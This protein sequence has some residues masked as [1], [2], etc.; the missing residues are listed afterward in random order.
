MEGPIVG[1]LPRTMLCCPVE[2][3]VADRTIDLD[4]AEGNLSLTGMFL[5]VE[6]LPVNAPVHIRFAVVPNVE[7]DGVI[8]CSHSG[9]AG[10]EFASTT[11]PARQGLYDLIAEF[12]PRELLAA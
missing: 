1:R 6:K 8:R 12:T 3:R 11:G 10:I 9:G 4:H 7:L 2:L 5:H